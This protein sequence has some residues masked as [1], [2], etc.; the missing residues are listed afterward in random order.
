M[1]PS[2]SQRRGID[3]IKKDLQIDFM[4]DEL[5]NGI[6]NVL[7]DHCIMP[8]NDVQY[9]R[10]E[11]IGNF[12]NFAKKLW[13]DFFKKQID[14]IPSFVYE[15]I[16]TIKNYYFQSP[17][18]KRY[19]LI[20]FLY[21]EIGFD[22]EQ[23]KKFESDLNKIMEREF[24][25]Y[26]LVNGIVTEISSK[27][28]MQE[29]EEAIQTPLSSVNQHIQK[30]LLHLSNRE[31]PDY[32]NSIKESISAVESLCKKIVGNDNATM[33][34]ALDEIERQGRIELHEDMK[35]AF[36]KLYHYTSDSGGI[37]HGLTEGDTP[38][39]FD[40]AKFMLVSCSAIVNYLI[41]KANHAGINLN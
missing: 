21:S 33:G 7:H 14:S 41:S 5:S 32:P 15:V 23:Q 29:I 8:F 35:D 19:D 39:D 17:Y 4:D 34:N 9:S 10:I 36:K 38:P 11:D 3:P 12:Y 22:V 2:F 28:E 25:G 20:E 13:G 31:N 16:R 24:C 40:D 18:N 26:R 30:G 1:T 27:E 6:W 37:R